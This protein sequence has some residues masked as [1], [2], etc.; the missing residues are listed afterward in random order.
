VEDK[1]EPPS[2]LGSD[3]DPRSEAALM[4][5]LSVR[6]HDRFQSM[7]DF[8]AALTGT[9]FE[10]PAP[11]YAQ[12]MQQAPPPY[13]PYEFMPPAAPVAPPPSGGGNKLLWIAIAVVAV[14][15]VGFLLMKPTPVPVP[16][17]TGA[18]GSS[19]PT[20]PSQAATQ[21]TGDYKGIL[22]QAT[23][24]DQKHSYQDELALLDKAI[25]LDP[26]RFEAYDLKAQ[27]YLYNFQQWPEAKDNFEKSLAHGGNATFHVMHDHGAGN[28][29][30]KCSGWLYVTRNGVEYKASDG[31][32]HKFN[33]KRG[34]ITDVGNSKP[35][36]SAGKGPTFDHHAF[37]MRINKVLWNLAPQGQFGDEQR[38]MILEI[39]GN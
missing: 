2:R 10:Q 20:G 1:L 13:Q 19:G 33:V 38:S 36:G 22:Q 5:A 16:G 35:F 4:R 31:S 29:T 8:S 15:V 11:Q 27:I 24:L 12:T 18:T 32:Q 9:A 7:Q 6:A 34:E 17:P 25:K 23:A 30:A 28:F 37:R 26:N 14:L 21:P 39:M 3:I